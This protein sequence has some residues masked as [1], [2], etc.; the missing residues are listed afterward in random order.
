M[1]ALSIARANNLS[2]KYTLCNINT[3]KKNKSKELIKKEPSQKKS[4]Q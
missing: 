4:K 2:I 3:K 1:P